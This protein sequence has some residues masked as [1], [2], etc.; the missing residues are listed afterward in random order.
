MSSRPNMIL[1]SVSESRAMRSRS[2]SQLWLSHEGPGSLVAA[3]CFPFQSW[4]PLAAIMRLYPGS[5]SLGGFRGIGL[6]RFGGV[7]GYFLD[8]FRRCYGFLLPAF[9][10]MTGGKGGRF[11]F[12]LL[13]FSHK[14]WLG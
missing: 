11:E 10:G 13:L 1:S 14:V 12:L 7:F 4:R 8:R 6:D 5:L 3:P 2:S 9:A